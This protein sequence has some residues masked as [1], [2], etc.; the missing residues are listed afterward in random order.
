MLCDSPSKV[1]PPG[2]P[3]E[4][5]TFRGLVGNIQGWP[6]SWMPEKKA[7]GPLDKRGRAQT[8]PLPG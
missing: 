5:E 4:G 8:S 6:L 1:T 7:P 2:A 3:E